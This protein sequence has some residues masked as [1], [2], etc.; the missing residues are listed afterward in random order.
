MNIASRLYLSIL[1]LSST[2]TLSGNFIRAAAQDSPT[3][4]IAYPQIVRLS[5]VQGDVRISRGK[6][7][8]RTTGAT[9]ERAS[10][11]IPLEEGFSLVTGQGRAEIEL[12]DASTLYLAENSA[13]VFNI[14]SSTDGVPHTAI[15]LLTGTINLNV[16]T[17]AAGEWFLLSTPT[18]AVS[19]RYPEKAYLRVNSYLDATAL[20][21][22]DSSASLHLTSGG[23][24]QATKGQTF[25]SHNGLPFVL[26]TSASSNFAEW[27]KWVADR[28][29]ARSD[30][31][32]AVMKDAGLSS[33]LPGLAD[34]NA[35]GTFFACAPYGTCWEPSHGWTHQAKA[36]GQPE[37]QQSA[38]AP[39]T[40]QQPMPQG[41]P[42]FQQVGYAASSAPYWEDEDPFPCS[43]DRL[44]YL[45]QD[46]PAT[47]LT[48]VIGSELV[49]DDYPY[50]WVVCNSGSWLYRQHR[51]VWV[52]GKRHH[53]PPLHWVKSGRTTGYVPRHPHD[54]EG[55]P[56][57][58]LKH[59][60]FVPN[61][62]SKSVEQ[63]AFDPKSSIK[64]LQEPPKDFRS[65]YFPPLARTE[66]PHLEAH[67]VK[68]TFTGNKESHGMNPGAI[69]TFDHKSQSFMLARQVTQGGRSTTISEP[70][71]GRTNGARSDGDSGRGGSSF[72]GNRGSGATGSSARS[73][74][75][76]GGSS[77]G[78]SSGSSGGSGGGGGGSH[79]SS[80]G[81][82]GGG[83][84]ASSG[85]GGA[86][87]GGGGGGGGHK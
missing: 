86:S 63:V 13:L 46:D 66:A 2:L 47:G 9:W 48:D 35:Q 73:G 68:D 51:Y 27:D 32:S 57:L 38:S 77:R 58:N 23:T 37:Y 8:E 25:T 85:G 84:G 1:L 26:D 87:S 11:N 62:K 44:R 65:P 39:S 19:L 69:I 81:G 33:P 59:G 17:I 14:L 54:V 80:G 49:D 7:A 41:S 40:P 3:P 55:K 4:P 42:Q 18:N 22:Q 71:G 72:G 10:A 31:L 53:H 5:L 74:G 78:S 50:D 43:P 56:P 12:E 24:V 83:G 70:F 52:V 20:T 75:S 21:P 45:L 82:G 16:K 61:N 30:S 6:Q 29:N 79:G 28:V 34:M 64:L 15:T 60:I 36:S 76:S 67:L